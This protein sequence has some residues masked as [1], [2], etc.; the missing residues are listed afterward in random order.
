MGEELYDPHSDCGDESIAHRIRRNQSG[1]RSHR[2]LVIDLSA[3]WAGPLCANL[4]WLCGA[5]VVKVES[6]DR[7]DGAREGD[8][9]FHA[10]L[11]QGK[12]SV[13]LDF[14]AESGRRMLRRLLE[15]ADIVIE[16]SRPR[17]LRHLGI[18][19]EDWVRSQDGRTWIGITGYG[20]DEPAGN[21]VAFGDDA[22]SRPGLP[23]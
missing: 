14:R 13:V 4:L 19:A 8:P 9:A 7:P 15:R 11:N 22:G 6:A 5:R 21:W 10:L 16:S 2:P 23:T 20:R 18:A 1:P 17:A 3:L 12:E